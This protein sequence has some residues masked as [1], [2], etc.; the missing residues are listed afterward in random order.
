MW[1]D[2]SDIAIFGRLNRLPVKNRR[3]KT[4]KL[5]RVGSFIRPVGAEDAAEL[6][7]VSRLSTASS[8]TSAPLG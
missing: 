3:Y 2:L 7:E 6:L 4:S 5:F 8:G 1:N